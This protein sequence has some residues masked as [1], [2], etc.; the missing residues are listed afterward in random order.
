MAAPLDASGCRAPRA[1]DR[2]LVVLSGDTH[3]VR[4]SDPTDFSG[5]RIG[6][7]FARPLVSSPGLEGFF[8]TEGPLAVAA[9]LTQ[10]IGPLQYADTARSGFMTVTASATDCHAEWRYLSM[11]KSRTFT[12]ANSPAL[13]MWPVAANRR[14]APG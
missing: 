10:I 7:E 2:N 12:V 8:T 13:R 3:N 5:H 9:G 4:A 1:L 11:V 14:I 6:V